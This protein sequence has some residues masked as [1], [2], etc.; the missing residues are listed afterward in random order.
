MKLHSTLLAVAM[1]SILAGPPAAAKEASKVVERA[2]ASMNELPRLVRETLEQEAE[3]GTIGELQKELRDD[4][5]VTYDAEIIREG[6]VSYVNVSSDGTIIGHAKR[7]APT[8][9]NK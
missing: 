9:T 6:K 4:D 1:F 3:G 2:H 5:S 7:R 8:P